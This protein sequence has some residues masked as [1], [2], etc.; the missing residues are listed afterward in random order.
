M[1]KIAKN[2]RNLYFSIIQN[3]KRLPHLQLLYSFLEVLLNLKA[4]QIE[5]CLY[6]FHDPEFLMKL[7]LRFHSYCIIEN[8]GDSH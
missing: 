1:S 2:L 5:E 4:N 7:G 8:I 6:L 3:L